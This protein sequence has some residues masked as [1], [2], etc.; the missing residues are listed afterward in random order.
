MKSFK[1]FKEMREEIF[2]LTVPKAGPGR[3]DIHFKIKGK[4]KIDAL[5]Q[6]RK[7]KSN[8]MFKND[9]VTIK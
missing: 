9:K 6:W 2:M 3:K 4:D 1:E 5:K 8:R 7:K